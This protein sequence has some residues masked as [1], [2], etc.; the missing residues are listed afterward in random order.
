M[1]RLQYTHLVGEVRGE[2]SLF[3]QCAYDCYKN[4]Q[5]PE[6]RRRRFNSVVMA[7]VGLWMFGH[8][9]RWAKKTGKPNRT[10]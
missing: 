7:P 2:S 8:V 5:K 10:G 6:E 3:L 4:L 9:E 1:T